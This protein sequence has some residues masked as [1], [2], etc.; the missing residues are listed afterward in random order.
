MRVQNEGTG[1]SS[2]WVMNPDASRTVKTPRR[3][4]A[5]T[6]D[7]KSYERQR[8]RA[9][10]CVGELPSS[11]YGGSLQR[12]AAS[13]TGVLPP[14]HSPASGGGRHGEDHPHRL[15]QQQQPFG[16]AADP[17]LN[18]S[19]FSSVD[20]YRGR[21]SSFG[22]AASGCVGRLS[23][24]ETIHESD[25]MMMSMMEGGA[26]DVCRFSIV[27]S[28]VPSSSSSAAAHLYVPDG[29]ETLSETLA[30]IFAGDL[31]M[32]DIG[33]L[34]SS[35]SASSMCRQQP[36]QQ[37]VISS[38]VD[39]SCSSFNGGLAMS[40][41]DSTPAFAG[42]TAATTSTSTVAGSAAHDSDYFRSAVS[43]CSSYGGGHSSS[44]QT[45]QSVSAMI[46]GVDVDMKPPVTGVY[47]STMTSPGYQNGNGCRL[48]SATAGGGQVTTTAAAAAVNG[49]CGMKYGGGMSTD[50]QMIDV[51][52]ST[53]TLM[54]C[55]FSGVGS[56]SN[57]VTTAL[58]HHPPPPPT[59]GMAYMAM[60]Q[61]TDMAMNGGHLSSSTTTGACNGS[62]FIW[63]QP[64]PANVVPTTTAQ[65]WS[66]QQQ[67][68][69]QPQQQQFQ[70]LT[71]SPQAA[72]NRGL[73]ISRLS[74]RGLG[75]RLNRA[76]I[77]RILAERPHLMEKMQQLIQM[78]RQQLFAQLQQQQ[79]TP[80]QQQHQ[81][82][83][84]MAAQ[85]STDNGYRLQQLLST[86]AFGGSGF[87][88]AT[89]ATQATNSNSC[90]YTSMF[91]S[92]SVKTE[93]C[94]SFSSFFPSDLDL[95][96]VEFSAPDM[97]CDIDQVIEHE[98][99]LDGKLD[100]MFDSLVGTAPA[101]AAAAAA[102]SCGA[103]IGG[104]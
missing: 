45:S 20:V 96:A 99:A 9:T 39:G 71:C 80:Q 62:D 48:M 30:D 85:A 35:T 100:F 57:A 10:G 53:T 64:A 94:P 40:S 84:Q 42:A 22:G 27:D 65:R 69:Q 41:Y 26:G 83:Q 5:L 75:G 4:R 28:P 87:Q 17:M 36:Q 6:L 49:H 59:C 32:S 81:H 58:H 25:M 97:D 31:S 3:P 67:Q 63:H 2:W 15:Q 56:P 103:V 72:L 82:H 14:R 90:S 92:S 68:Q 33:G 54:S 76:A 93:T 38:A 55:M 34:G 44:H 104:N 24:I 19:V 98:L 52:P 8:R 50:V 7:T 23:P 12:P 21:A 1:K 74:N 16:A 91:D 70:Q 29:Q 102:A 51:K 11:T 47:G 43:R 89:A 37:Q 18:D 46:A 88:N 60:Q 95:N 101:A 86:T 66:Q 13:T 61:Q 73:D 78:K 79:Q 77:A